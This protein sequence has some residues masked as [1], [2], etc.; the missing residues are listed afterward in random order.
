MNRGSSASWPPSFPLAKSCFVKGESH[1]GLGW[2]TIPR[3]GNGQETANDQALPAVLIFRSRIWK[4]IF[5]IQTGR[6]ELLAIWAPAWLFD[7]LFMCKWHSHTLCCE[8]IE[9]KLLLILSFLYF[10]TRKSDKLLLANNVV[11]M[12]K[13]KSL[14]MYHA[15]YMKQMVL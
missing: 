5:S 7:H 3:D 1:N 12:C 2:E 11:F 9:Y 6:I 13:N 10:I 8:P 15:N 14:T 4:G